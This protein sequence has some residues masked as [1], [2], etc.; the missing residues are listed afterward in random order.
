VRPDEAAVRR[1][2]EPG[3]HTGLG[4][5][6]G[7]VA[8]DLGMLEFEGRAIQ[9]GVFE[10]FKEAVGDAGLREV[11]QRIAN[12]W[13]H[14]SPS[15]GTN[16]LFRCS[17]PVEG[18]ALALRP[19]TPEE[20]VAGQR[21]H[22]RAMAEKGHASRTL[23]ATERPRV[24]IEIRGQGQ[25][26]ILPPSNG[27]VH[28]TGL[29]YVLRRGGFGSIAT[30]TGAELED[31][32]EVA[33]MFHQ[34]PPVAYKPP[35]ERA[36]TNGRPGDDF[37]AR[38]DW[39]TILEPHGWTYLRTTVDGNQHWCRPGKVCTTSATIAQEGSGPLYVFSTSTPFPQ[40]A[41]AYSK[42]A[43]H[44]FLNHAGD[45]RAAALGV[46]A[47]GYG[48]VADEHTFGFPVG[49][50]SMGDGSEV[51]WYLRFEAPDGE[52]ELSIDEL[53]NWWHVE[54]KFMNQFTA[55]PFYRPNK[56]EWQVR[57]DEL[58]LTAKRRATLPG[59][60]RRDRLA[61]Q[62]KSFLGRAMAEPD[63]VGW[64]GVWHDEENQAYVFQASSVMTFLQGGNYVYPTAKM[65]EIRSVLRDVFGAEDYRPRRPLPGLEHRPRLI[66]V[67]VR[68]DED[69]DA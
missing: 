51:S 36:P 29:P 55:R 8:G 37:N 62:I 25:Y 30:I 3:Q 17:E 66:R 7:A 40:A 68:P 44:A 60:S 15:G 20:L 16:F 34:M 9:E 58:V 22:D 53:R 64:R 18:E 48:Q 13:A 57:L 42:F 39:R 33:R 54:G 6:C 50:E 67:P 1:W 24:L 10:R 38:A 43:A 56:A 31:L 63:R 21:E 2:Y 23:K 41:R 27:G 47:Q 26:A 46:L 11:M 12:G 19:A 35:P 14:A 5:L 45:F 59:M 49:L 28:P 52:L 61:D 69:R 65:T 4:S 32:R